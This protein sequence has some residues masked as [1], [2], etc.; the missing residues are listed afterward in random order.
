[1]P[2]YKGY[3]NLD[4]LIKTK[5]DWFNRKWWGGAKLHRPIEW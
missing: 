2:I 3:P 5:G 4:E 1:M